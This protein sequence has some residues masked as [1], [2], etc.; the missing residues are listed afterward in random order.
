MTDDERARAAAD[1]FRKQMAASSGEGGAVDGD[2]YGKKD[3]GAGGGGGRN[4]R[5]GQKREY[6]RFDADADDDNADG[7]DMEEYHRT[8]KSRKDPMNEMKVGDDG[9]LPMQ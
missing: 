3:G 9:L 8:K 6:G 4:E 5:V 2:F 7:V 1:A